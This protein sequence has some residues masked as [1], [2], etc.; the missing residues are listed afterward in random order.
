MVGLQPSSSFN[1]L[2]PLGVARG[3]G[4]RANLGPNAWALPVQHVV[5][6]RVCPS[7]PPLYLL[8][9]L[10]PAGRTWVSSTGA[11]RLAAPALGHS[12]TEHRDLGAEKK[13]KVER[14]GRAPRPA[15]RAHSRCQRCPERQPRNARAGGRLHR[16]CTAPAPPPPRPT[17]GR[18]SHPLGLKLATILMSGLPTIRSGSPSALSTFAFAALSAAATS[19]VPWLVFTNAFRADP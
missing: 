8:C 12:S 15:L 18:F 11:L 17:G 19:G 13:V 3:L 4:G 6:R 10:S 7:S 1:Y 5:V 9:R 2:T 16:S 14:G